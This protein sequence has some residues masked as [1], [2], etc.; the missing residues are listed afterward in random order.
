MLALQF[1]LSILTVLFLQRIAGE[2]KSFSTD[3]WVAPK[4]SKRMDKFMLYM[5]TAGKKALADG[6]ITEDV[7]NELDQARCGVLIGSAI[8]G[9][10]VTSSLQQFDIQYIMR[11]EHG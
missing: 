6:G 7:M 5:L 4:L 9:M 8:G 10:K 3:G 2:I 1:I 11:M